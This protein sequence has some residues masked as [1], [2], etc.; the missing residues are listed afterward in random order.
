MKY[1]NIFFAIM[2]LAFAALQVNDPD[3]ILWI[4][5]YG[6][7]AVVSVMAIFDYYNRWLMAA[8]TL[9]YLI[10][11]AI[12]FPGVSEWL[13]QDDKSVLF[14]DVMKMQ[15]PYIEESREFLG[16]LICQLVLVLCFFRSFRKKV[17]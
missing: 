2:F 13:Q 6:V 8:L 10:Y 7:M 3:P 5:I 12:L 11:L 17:A 9:F 14:D 4:L 16:L 1:L 15:F